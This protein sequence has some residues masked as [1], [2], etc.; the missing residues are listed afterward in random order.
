VTKPYSPVDLLRLVRRY[1][2]ETAQR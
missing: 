1:L 2:G